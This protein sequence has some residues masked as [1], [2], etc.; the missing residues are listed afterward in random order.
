MRGGV[1]RR[2]NEDSRM[3]QPQKS[4]ASPADFPAAERQ[5]SRR[6]IKQLIGAHGTSRG[7]KRF[8]EYPS[9]RVPRADQEVVG[10]IYKEECLALKTSPRSLQCE[11]TTSIIIRFLSGVYRKGHRVKPRHPALSITCR[12]S[13]TTLPGH[14]QL[15]DL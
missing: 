12:Q 6:R 3:D 9:T 5:E 10:T 1:P 2:P 14:G 4:N 15:V 7:E 8:D 13:L 11:Q